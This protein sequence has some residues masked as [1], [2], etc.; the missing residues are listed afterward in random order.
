M[1]EAHRQAGVALADVDAIELG[2]FRARPLR[3]RDEGVLVGRGK[4]AEVRV[5]H[6]QVSSRHATISPLS[7]QPIGLDGQPVGANDGVVEGVRLTNGRAFSVQYHPEAAAG[8]HDANYLFDQ[9]TDL[10]ERVK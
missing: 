7:L 5:Q 10:M 4:S 6:E 3:P 8:P 1:D 2:S 9:F